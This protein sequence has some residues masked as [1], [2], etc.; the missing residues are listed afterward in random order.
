MLY[1]LSS[2]FVQNLVQIGVLYLKCNSSLHVYQLPEKISNLCVP[3]DDI[4]KYLIINYFKT[5][6]FIWGLVLL[7]VFDFNN[8]C[9]HQFFHDFP[10]SNYIH[11]H[12]ISLSK[13]MKQSEIKDVYVYMS[14]SKTTSIYVYHFFTLTLWK[15]YSS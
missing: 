8:I 12:N 11:V 13:T 4:L 2:E 9:L 1:M 10:K 15:H 14:T 6:D 7:W 3:L 5:C